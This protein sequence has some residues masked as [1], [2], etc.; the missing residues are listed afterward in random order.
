MPPLRP[1]RVVAPPGRAAEAEALIS[2][3]RLGGEVAYAVADAR[4]G[5]VLEARGGDLALPPGSVSKAVTAL[6]ALDALGANHRFLTRLVATGPVQGGRLAG[7][8]LLVGGGDPTLDT[9]RLAGLAE[10]L[11]ERGLREVSGRFL[12]HAATLPAISRIDPDQPE[13]VGYNPAIS[14]LNLNYNRVHFQWTRSGG[15]WQILLDARGERFRPPVNVAEMRV[16]D[17]SLPV[18]TYS[19]ADTVDR[20]TVAAQALGD[21]GGR[22]LPVRRPELYAGDVFRT[23]SQSF[24][25]TLPPPQTVGASGIE[26]TVLVETRSDALGPILAGMLRF[27]TNLTAEVAGLSASLARG[28]VPGSLAA[29]GAMMAD[30]AAAFGLRGARLADHSGLGDASRMA[31]Q[32]L[33]A[34]LASAHGAGVLRG[35]LHRF[36]MRD[37]N[38]N[39]V[40]NHPVSVQAKTGTL[41]FVS[42][43][44]GYFNGRGGGDLV[45]AIFAA[46]MQTRSRLTGDA[47]E[48]PPGGR[49]WTRRARTLQQQLIERWAAIY[50]A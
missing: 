9:D 47:R 46:D 6:Y 1:A 41:N 32:A 36:E 45:F 11:R 20:W 23:L 24:G 44:G 25:L 28:G 4:S 43:L 50:P 37:R 13:H 39:P 38:G 33:T 19:D 34:F 15:G 31:P 21:A 5:R 14:A 17:R 22:W 49:E 8:L 16:V 42:G 27:S 30:W 12:V 10:A 18:Y 3:A 29:S 35:M 2:A 40:R 26:G 48:R 7:D